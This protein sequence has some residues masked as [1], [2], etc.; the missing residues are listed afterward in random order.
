VQAAAAVAELDLPMTQG[1]LDDLANAHLI[2]PTAQGR[3]RFHDLLRTYAADQAHRSDRDDDRD[4]AL[5]TLLGWYANTAR[6]CDKLV[7][8]AHPRLHLQLFN[9]T[10]QASVL[11]R[12]QALDWLRSERRN[13][14]ASLQH[15]IR[16]KM[17][18]HALQLADSM[19]FLYMLGSW[20]EYLEVNSY[21]LAAARDCSDGDAETYFILRRGSPFVE[22]RRW[23]EAQDEYDQA[24]VL[25]RALDNRSYQAAV[26]I[27]LGWL[28]CEREQFE[29][30]LP[31]LHEALPLS[32]DV[33]TGR[34]EAVVEGN[35][36]RAYA[37]LGHYRQA[38]EHGERGL[39]LRRHTDDLHGV[40]NAMHHVARAWQGLGEHEKAIRICREAITLGRATGGFGEMIAEPLNTLAVSLHHTGNAAEAVTYWREAAILFEDH[41]R[42]HQAAQVRQRLHAAQIPSELDGELR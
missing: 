35:L 42:P 26:L 40:P 33:D 24:S 11:D 28:C 32:R 38:I 31:Y 6:I 27:D 18:E 3:Y 8:P 25:A 17:R 12:V 10:D 2:E 7:Y 39:A 1:L 34:W 29:D 5:Q 19:R 4:R 20:D 14:L 23:D 22:L 21:G 16:H 13:L 37:G 9:V 30:A 41:G 36:S 15:A